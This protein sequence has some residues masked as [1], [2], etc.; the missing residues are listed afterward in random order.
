M[1]SHAT[2]LVWFRRDLRLRD[3]PA[4]RYAVAHAKAVIPVYVFAPDEEGEW[5]P[6]AASRW[7]LHH[8]LLALDRELKRRGSRLI[9]RAGATLDVLRTL[10]Q[11]T[12]ATLVT[13]NRLYEPALR[14]RDRSIETALGD[15]MQI[16]SCSPSL[17]FEPGSIRNGQGQPY[18]V[19]T[20]FW[21]KAQTQLEQLPPPAVAPR[22]LRAPV[23]WPRSE[24]L[25]S[26]SLLPRIRWDSAFAQHWSA[27]EAG[28]WSA[29]RAFEKAVADYDSSRNRPDMIGTSRLSP[30]LHFG[31][32]GPLQIFS[33]MR[34]RRLLGTGA[35]TFRRELGWREFAHHL[36]HDFPDTPT[37]PLD[38]RFERMPWSRTRKSLAAWQ[39]GMTGYPI[40]DAG[41]RELWQTG[42]MHNRVRMIV[43][44]FL[45][46]NL[47]HHW[48]DGARWFW[49]TLVDA[50]LAN[51]T[52]GWQWTAGCGADA[53]PYYRIFNPVLQAER[54]DTNRSYI[55][56]WIPELA[57]LPDRWIH[58]P[59]A[60]SPATLASAGVQLGKNYPKPVV[61]LNCSRDDAM[62]A[63][64]H[65]QIPRD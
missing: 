51:N 52:L 33:H 25:E 16:E 58:Q 63:Y 12:Q 34:Q 62:K 15:R 6:G 20:A 50:N 13:F 3:N 17:L 9:L 10:Q 46:K 23:S 56:R 38:R 54:F 36:L 7:W 1:S 55:R 47:Q 64:R 29:L 42:W 19:F 37:R 27:G 31:E 5:A 4:L 32:I 35:E 28:A 22:S 59:W 43:A 21:R 39:R 24:Q 48:V 60:A 41:L 8:S 49:D 45:T 18:K 26:L 11:E 65:I 57:A 44:S 40:V 53:A 14:A 61:E 30:H 2:A